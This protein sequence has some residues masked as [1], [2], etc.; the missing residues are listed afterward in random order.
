MRIPQGYCE[1]PTIFS[2]AMAAN[3]FKFD[4]PNKSQVLLYVDDI[5]LAGRTEEA[6]KQDTLALLRFLAEQG[7]NAS[8]N[9]LQLWEEKVRY[10]GYDISREGKTLDQK[11][12]E[13][14]LKTPKPTAQKRDDVTF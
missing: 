8:K 4:P 12:K 13:A 2:Q 6:C 10:L 5:L 3:L 11:R 14:I 9:K 1:S 7:N